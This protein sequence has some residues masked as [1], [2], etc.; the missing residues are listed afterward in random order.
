MWP[1]LSQ[2][3]YNAM[4]FVNF[5]RGSA[6]ERSMISLFFDKINDKSISQHYHESEPR[7]NPTSDLDTNKSSSK[8]NNH[9]ESSEF[10]LLYSLGKVLDLVCTKH[11]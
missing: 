11:P 10:H 1:C 5:T 9:D 6:R 3:K 7:E 8:P 2:K 4:S